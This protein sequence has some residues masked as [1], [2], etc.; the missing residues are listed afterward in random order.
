[1]RIKDED[2]EPYLRV[3][4]IAVQGLMNRAPRRSVDSLKLEYLVGIRT[5]V[6]DSYYASLSLALRDPLLFQLHRD[7]TK[8]PCT[9]RINYHLRKRRWA[10]EGDL[11]ILHDKLSQEQAERAVGLAFTKPYLVERVS[12]E[13]VRQAERL[14]VDKL[15]LRARDLTY[16]DDALRRADE[17][18]AALRRG[19]EEP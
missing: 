10:T 6:S 15:G 16:F 1:M 8:L 13:A 19:R 12:G 14:L 3:V 5:H 7:S 11:F 2:V 17:A 9:L 4:A 18:L